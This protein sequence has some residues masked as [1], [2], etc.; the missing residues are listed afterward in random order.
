MSQKDRQ[1]YEQ[2][3]EV[4]KMFQQVAFH[5]IMK[6]QGQ[7][8]TVLVLEQKSTA[9]WNRQIID[10]DFTNSVLLILIRANGS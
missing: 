2:M 6:H 8:S 4:C 9:D 1:D 5:S 7:L 3:E 10:M